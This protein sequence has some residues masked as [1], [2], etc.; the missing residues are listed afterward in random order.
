M[1]SLHSLKSSS[2]FDWFDGKGISYLWPPQWIAQD[3]L[4]GYGEHTFKELL[5]GSGREIQKEED[6]CIHTADSLP[7]TAETNTKL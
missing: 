5:E 7:C 3:C 4:E 6:M 1:C 2:Q